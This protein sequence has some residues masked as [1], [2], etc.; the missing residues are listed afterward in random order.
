MKLKWKGGDVTQATAAAAQEA[1]FD[2]G[3]HILDTSNQL[4]PL[5]DGTL[6]S[7]GMV[8]ATDTS[9]T[10]SYDTPYAVRQ[11]E[12]TT[13]RH[14]NGRSAKFLETAITSE[15]EAVLQFLQNRLKE[16]L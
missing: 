5:D 6:V 15:R 4:A 11:H 10:I 13:L 7:S 16:V 8:T 1:L 14:P 3:Q 9:V 2:A 12:D